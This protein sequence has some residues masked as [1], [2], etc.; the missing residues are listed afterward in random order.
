M[1]G[2]GLAGGFAAGGVK[3]AL[4]DLVKQRMLEQEL[5]QREEEQQFQRTRANRQDEQAAAETTYRHGQ[6]ALTQARLAEQDALAKETRTQ[7]NEIGRYNLLKGQPAADIKA[8]LGEDFSTG[9]TIPTAPNPAIP[10]NMPAYLIGQNT[11]S[12]PMLVNGTRIRPPS[13]E[14]L[15]VSEAADEERKTQNAI[16]IAQAK[17]VNRSALS[18]FVG[19]KG[20]PLQQDEQGH[21]YAGP[22]EIPLAQVRRAPPQSE[23]RERYNV[24][25]ITNKDG[26]TGLVRVNLDTGEAT[27]VAT[28]QGV[29]GYGRPSDVE[30]Q[31]VSYYDRAKAADANAASFED[32]MHDLGPQLQTKLP[33]FLQSAAGQQYSQAQREF[34]EAR[35]RKE[36]GAAIPASELANDAKTYF[37]QPGDTPQVIA[38]K[39]A[40]RARFLR[41]LNKTTGN[42]QQK[43][44]E[45][46]KSGAVEQWHRD[47]SG[48]LVKG[49]G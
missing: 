24:Q 25:P 8:S 1:A 13:M 41:G 7:Q 29:G 37:V 3:D 20:E 33:S 12:M 14:D 27:I 16:R 42:L 19:P 6:D 22:T 4:L 35:L 2:I 10:G 49:G 44:D 21:I 39:Q 11:K 17:P 28:P 18:G 36:S 31:A 47:A 46:K 15:N 34:T 9:Q 32:A 40:S 48:K 38:Q 43:E 30:R 5:A 45:T 26:T 23:P